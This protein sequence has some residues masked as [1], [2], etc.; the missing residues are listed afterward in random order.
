MSLPKRH[1]TFAD[2]L[3]H[4]TGDGK[5]EFRVVVNEVSGEGEVKIYI[6]PLGKDG[7]SRDFL[8]DADDVTDITQWLP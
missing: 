5:T 4:E 6:H 2:Y 7:E 8:V 3:I 1:V